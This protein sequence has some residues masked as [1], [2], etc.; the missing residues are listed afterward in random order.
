MQS[1]NILIV[2]DDLLTLKFYEAYLKDPSFNV[3][4]ATSGKEC[5]EQ[6]KNNAISL[7][8]L[9]V[10]IPDISGY[11]IA[12]QLKLGRET[13]DIPIVFI[14]GNTDSFIDAGKGFELGAVDFL[15]KPVEAKILRL[16]SMALV[17]VYEKHR[18]ALT[19][20]DAL[21]ITCKDLEDRL[22]TTFALFPLAIFTMD[23][24]GTIS[25]CSAKLELLLMV[26]RSEIVGRP[27]GSLLS[28]Q[29]RAGFDAILS[30]AFSTGARQEFHCTLMQS[31]GQELQVTASLTGRGACALCEISRDNP[32]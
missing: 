14:T 8:I 17:K 32:A 20:L 16:K 10:G 7:I 30:K 22:E 13:M 1:Y 9:D 28:D 18:K 4:K 11:E 6:V 31:R 29:S 21:K 27:F 2:D 19:E 26:K 3:I 15:T 5:F 24:T 23:K 25:E 12:A